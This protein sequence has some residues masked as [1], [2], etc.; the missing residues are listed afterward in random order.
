MT[1]HGDLDLR[2]VEVALRQADIPENAEAVKG[3]G[4]PPTVWAFYRAILRAF[5]ALG[6]APDRAWL[7]HEAMVHGVDREATLGEL[8]ARDMIARDP[9]TGALTVAY[10]FSAVPTAHRV[11]VDEARPVYAMCAVDALGIPFMLGRDA[12]I[13]SAD[14]ISGAPIRIEVRAGAA[15]WEP[16]GAVIF[17]CAS[18][19]CTG[20]SHC[21]AINF[22]A[23]AASAGHFR[24]AHPE[25]EG[26]VLGPAEAL[27]A[28]RRVFGALLADE[29][30]ATSG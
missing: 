5:P 9:A 3:V 18:H 11:L 29:G 13:M 30:P 14:P 26:C 7:D 16:G 17:V 27:E 8:A 21:A 2:A 4:L 23:S 15:S 20:P 24:Q 6:G 28:G 10:P 19:G 12:T 25:V 1:E 22:F